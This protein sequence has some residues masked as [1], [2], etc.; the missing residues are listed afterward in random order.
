ERGE[1]GRRKRCTNECQGPSGVMTALL[2]VSYAERR[3]CSRSFFNVFLFSFPGQM[4]GVCEMQC[5]VVQRQAVHGGPQVQDVALGR[6]ISLKALADVLAQVNR[7]GA[8]AIARLTM[9]GARTTALL[10]ATAQAVE[11]AE[12]SQDLLH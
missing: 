7:E 11:E 4:E 3:R 8:L 5:S 6:A 10:T 12:V 2:R 9:H 1:K